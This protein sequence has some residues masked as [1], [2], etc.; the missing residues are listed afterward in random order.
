MRLGDIKLEEKDEM[1]LAALKNMDGGRTKRTGVE[2]QEN[3]KVI[4]DVE[5]NCMSITPIEFETPYWLVE[6]LQ[7]LF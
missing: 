5:D 7:S 1:M 2:K 6:F 3:P 4:P